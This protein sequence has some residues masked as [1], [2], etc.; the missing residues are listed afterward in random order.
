MSRL[1]LPIVDELDLTEEFTSSHN[2]IAH[3]QKHVIDEHRPDIS[4]DEYEKDADR[5]ASAKIDNKI[6]FGYESTTREGRTAYC[7]YNKETALF[8]VYFYRQ[9]NKNPQIITAY[10]KSWRDFTGD[11]AIE[12]FDEIPQG[13]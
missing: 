5:L 2:K 7:K 12:Y 11:K 1:K 4:V 8:V 10:W 3:Y 13:K 6:I 9:G